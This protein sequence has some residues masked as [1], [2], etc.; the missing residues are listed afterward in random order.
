M[1]LHASTSLA[2]TVAKHNQV[3]CYSNTNIW[4]STCDSLKSK[5]STRGEIKVQSR[6]PL[7]TSANCKGSAALARLMLGDQIRRYSFCHWRGKPLQ[8]LFDSCVTLLLCF[9]LIVFYEVM[10][11]YIACIFITYDLITAA[12]ELASKGQWLR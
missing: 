7:L 5:V 6:E 3:V 4:H 11:I 12:G 9:F 1:F 2:R 10:L 8:R